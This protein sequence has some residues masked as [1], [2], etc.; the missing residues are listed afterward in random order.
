MISV[1]KKKREES[2]DVFSHFSLSDTS[3]PL[4]TLKPLGRNLK[5]YF[6]YKL[7]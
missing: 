6:S 7:Y 3:D 5:C 2:V 4:L 1:K